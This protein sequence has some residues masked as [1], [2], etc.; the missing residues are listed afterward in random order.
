MWLTVLQNKSWFKRMNKIWQKKDDSTKKFDEFLSLKGRVFISPND[1]KSVTFYFPLFPLFFQ[2]L[3]FLDNVLLI[4]FAYCHVW[5]EI[6]ICLAIRKELDYLLINLLQLFVFFCFRIQ[7]YCSMRE[8]IHFFESNFKR[9]KQLKLF[10]EKI[11]SFLKTVRMYKWET[12][13]DVG[14]PSFVSRVINFPQSLDLLVVKFCNYWQGSISHEF[15]C[16]LF[17]LDISSLIR[18]WCL[19]NNWSMW[20]LARK[21]F[22][23]KIDDKFEIRM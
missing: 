16:L 20:L 23:I 17:H 18:F 19:I 2:I 11:E 1:V 15:C 5:M 4:K 14:F 6:S 8:E 13:I 10:L 7:K 3:V 12:D 9:F 21:F 22:Y